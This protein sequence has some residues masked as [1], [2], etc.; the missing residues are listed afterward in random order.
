MNTTPREIELKFNF[1]HADDR[2]LKRY[3]SRAA[4]KRPISETLVS[5]YFDTPDLQLLARGISLRVRRSGKRYRQ[6]IKVADERAA[7]LFDR[8]EWEQDI[9]GPEPD[10]S[11]AA[12]IISDGLLNGQLPESLQPVFET[13][14]RRITYHI[15]SR[16]QRIELTLDQGEIDTG[17]RRAPICE[18]ELELAQGDRGSLFEFAKVLNDLAPLRL[19]VKAKADRGYELLRNDIDPVDRAT[20]IHLAPE[21]TTQEA[22][23]VIGNG[24]LRQ[25]VANEPAMIAGDTEALHQMRIALRRL[26]AAMSVFANVVADSDWLNI[27]SGLRWVTGVLGPVRDLDVF[28]TEVLVPLRANNAKEPGVLNLFRDFERRRAR[29]HKETVSTIRSAR[30]HSLVLDTTAWI[31][32]GPWTRD[33]DDLLQLRRGQSVL[34]HASEELTRRRRKLKRKGKTFKELSPLERH[35]LRIATKKF[36]YALEFFSDLFP[37]K[38]RKRRCEQALSA[39]KELQDALG[40]LNDI[41]VRERLASKVA[42]SKRL[43]PGTPGTR[44]RAFAAGLIFG[45]QEAHVAGLLD[46]AEE[47]YTRLLKV[48]AF[49]T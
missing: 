24:C 37:G 36:R 16:G 1:D 47:A 33:N 25:L 27:K 31:E 45:S 28:V 39:L 12:G 26:R 13:R 7:G 3:L 34:A 20:D 9:K 18:L 15:A 6:T 19:A 5:V 48:K 22:F 46:T 30:F 10:L 21:M 40:G 43:N 4:G 8:V 2:R 49:W 44:D 17:K 38:T 35:M 41:A 42:L 32:V 29:A 14:V 23:R 11:A